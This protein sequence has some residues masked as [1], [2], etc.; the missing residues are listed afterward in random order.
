MD[1]EEVVLSGDVNRMSMRE[2]G[3]EIACW[4][5]NV[6]KDIIGPKC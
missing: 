5:E 1:G 3:L 2:R 4:A 6:N